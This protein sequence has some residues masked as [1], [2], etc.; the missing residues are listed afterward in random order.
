MSTREPVKESFMVGG[1]AAPAK[2]S[3]EFADSIKRASFISHALD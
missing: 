1:Q 3:T 2:R